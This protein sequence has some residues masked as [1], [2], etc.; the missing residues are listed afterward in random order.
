MA[1]L[2]EA[3]AAFT[4]GKDKRGEDGL[5]GRLFF[6]RAV[7]HQRALPQEHDAERRGHFFSFE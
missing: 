1:T 5:I 2:A 4:A 6:D 3:N 7:R